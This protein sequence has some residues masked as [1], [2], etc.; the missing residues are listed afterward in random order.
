VAEPFT[1]SWNA[2]DKTVVAKLAGLWDDDAMA[3]WE[4]T[5]TDF[6]DSANP[7]Y[8]MLSDMRDYPAQRQEFLLRHGALLDDA[9]QRGLRRAVAIVER[10]IPQMQMQRITN[11][12]TA[13]DRTFFVSNEADG[14]RILRA[15][16]PEQALEIARSLS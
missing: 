1:I 12:G 8:S 6:V 4:Q 9:A 5:V 7:G 10:V 14:W 3:A 15:E 13:A 16:T 11:N 2:E